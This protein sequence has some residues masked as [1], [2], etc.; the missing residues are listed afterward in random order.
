[1]QRQRAPPG[2]V[3]MILPDVRIPDLPDPP[4]LR[5]FQGPFPRGLLIFSASSHRQ[6]VVGRERVAGGVERL[7]PRRRGESRAGVADGEA[8]A[9][10]RGWI[11]MTTH[12][13][14]GD[15]GEDEGIQDA[16][17]RHVLRPVQSAALKT[18]RSV[19]SCM[20]TG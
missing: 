1:M 10:R 3:E 7:H 15:E 19:S 20:K 6:R 5:L 18:I 12:R 14:R 13:Q 11:Y 8:K 17:R 16:L 2:A 4:R 9:S